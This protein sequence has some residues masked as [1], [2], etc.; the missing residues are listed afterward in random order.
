MMLTSRF[1]GPFL[2]A[3]IYIIVVRT[4]KPWPGRD[5]HTRLTHPLYSGTTTTFTLS[6]LSI[7]GITVSQKETIPGPVAPQHSANYARMRER[8][9]GSYYEISCQTVALRFPPWALLHMVLRLVNRSATVV[10][11]RR[12]HRLRYLVQ[13]LSSLIS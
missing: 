8:E 2:V 9:P 13:I 3:R 7:C 10:A 11:V 12:P 4:L 5:W 1:T 6:G